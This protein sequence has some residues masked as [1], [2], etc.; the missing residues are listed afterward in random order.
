MISRSTRRFLAPALAATVALGHAA[1]GGDSASPT[2]VT[3]PPSVAGNYYLQWTLQVLRKSD[4]FQTQFQCYGQ[5]TLVQGAG[6]ATLSGFAVVNGGCAPE[7]YDLSGTVGAGG[8]I[9]FTTNGPKPPE[10][11]CPGGKDVRF[12]GQVTTADSYSMLTAR[13]VTTV[14]CPQ[15][16]E[17][18]FTYLIY[19]SK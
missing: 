14:T 16:G 4:G 3:P 15:Y 10:G 17:H 2:S 18:E 8:T 5:M 6:A 13:G 12:S 7:S 19:A 9:E 11:P 1:C